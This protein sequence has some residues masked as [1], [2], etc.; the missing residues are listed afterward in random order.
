MT[1]SGWAT[2]FGFVLILTALA[3]P[4]GLI[5]GQGLHGP[6]RDPHA[7]PRRRRAVHL[8]DPA[9]RPG[10]PAGLEAVRQKPHHLLARGLAAALPDPAHADAVGLHR[11]EPAA[12]QIRHLGPVV[13]H[14]LVVP[15]EHQLAV[16][17]RRDDAQ[18]LQPDGGPD[19]AELPL[20]RHRDHRGRRA[21]AGHRRP[22]RQE[23]RQ[24]LARPRA[25]AAL[26]DAPDRHHR[27]DHPALA[28]RDPEL[29]ELPD[30]PHPD[31]GRRSRSRW[32][33]SPRRR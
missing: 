11:P 14:D 27:R 17:R 4:L 16:L 30:R 9:R 3:F 13:Q 33:P 32:G 25:H 22:Q 6:A 21:R 8:P 28:G 23:P 18:L 29:R 26:R 12:L 10:G 20:R 2:I 5:P 7:G 1:F 24:L 15:D 31:G 19:R